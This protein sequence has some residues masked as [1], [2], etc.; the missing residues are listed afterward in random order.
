MRHEEHRV[1]VPATFTDV[2]FHGIHH[3]FGNRLTCIG[4]FIQHVV[5]SFLTTHQTTVVVLLELHHFLLSTLDEGSFGVRCHQVIGR[6]RQTTASGLAEAHL[7]HVIEQMNSRSPSKTLV[8]VTDCTGQVTTPHGP[9][10]EIHPVR[11]HFI[12]SHTSWSRFNDGSIAAGIIIGLESLEL[13]QTHFHFRMQGNCALCKCEIEFV[14]AGKHHSFT[15]LIGH[16]DSG[17]VA[18]HH[19]VL[20]GTHD[21][22]TVGWSEYV[23]GTHHQRVGFNLC[24]NRKRQVN[25]H[26]VAIE[27]SVETFADQGV[28]MNG[29]ALNQRGFKGLNSHSVKRWSTIQQNRVVGNYLFQDIPNL[30]VLPLQHF[31]GRLDGI[32]MAEFLESSNDEWLIEFQGDFLGQATL[33]QLQTRANNNHASSRIIN[34]FTKQVFTKTTLLTLDHIGQGFQ[35]TIRGTQHRPLAAIVIKQ[36][37]NRLLQHPFFVADNDFGCVQVHQFPQAVIA[38]DDT[39]IQVIQVTGRKVATVQQDKRAEI[40][41]DDRDHI[42]DHPFG[43][44]VTVT[45]GLDNF[46]PV[47]QVF[48]FLFGTSLIEFDSQ[49]LGQLDQIQFIEQLTDRFGTHIRLKGSISKLGPRGAILFFGEQLLWFQFGRTRIDD[50]VI[51]EVDHF[52]KRTGFHVQQ[53]PEPGRHRFKEPDMNHGCS[54]FDVPHSLTANTTVSDFHTTAVTDHALVLHSTVLAASTLPV[55]LRSENTLT[56]QAILL[57]T[58]SSVVDRFGFLDFPE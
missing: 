27:V 14:I 20:R 56:E 28:Q 30:F 29:V 26:L 55:L 57:R 47:D 18:T 38:V 21:R 45:N 37:V 5:V 15:A 22:L 40:R 17:V 9:I 41:W 34:A 36:S 6:K 19:D 50:H 51:L 12:E 8:A 48:L 25:C 7:H 24:L 52:L 32:G 53:V 3:V 10:V 11:K 46:E 49:L 39:P 58:I 42:E 54:K 31:L 35:R 23:V 44:I 4:P 16:L 2:I 33:M 43:S 13:G 1:D